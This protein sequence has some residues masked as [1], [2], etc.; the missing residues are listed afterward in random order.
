[1]GHEHASILDDDKPEPGLFPPTCS[2]GV[3]VSRVPERCRTISL[4]DH[5]KKFPY[6]RDQVM[7]RLERMGLRQPTS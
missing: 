3:S 2:S 6:L 4:V 7:P 1:M 5:V